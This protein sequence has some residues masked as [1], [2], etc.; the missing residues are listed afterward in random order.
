MVLS[1]M[2]H[3]QKALIYYILDNDIDLFDY[4]WT[5]VTGYGVFDGNGHTIS[6]LT[7]DASMFVFR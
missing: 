4:K 5:G 7:I 1:N 3:K 2:G 6:N